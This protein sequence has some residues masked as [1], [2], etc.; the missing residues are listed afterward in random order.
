MAALSLF[1]GEKRRYKK[2]NEN[3]TRTDK[4]SPVAASKALEEA[5]Q[6]QLFV[7]RHLLPLK[8]RGTEHEQ[9]A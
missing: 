8:L 7:L 1:S 4:H 5:L 3:K 2:K 9:H 6:V